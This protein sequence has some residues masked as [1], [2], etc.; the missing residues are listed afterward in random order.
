MHRQVHRGCAG[1]REVLFIKHSRVTDNLLLCSGIPEQPALVV[2]RIANEDTLS[3]MRLQLLPLVLLDV[4]IGSASKDPQVRHI[5]LALVPQ[6]KG[7][8]RLVGRGE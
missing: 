3:R 1:T 7:S 4:H 2:G 6:L 8:G 5:R